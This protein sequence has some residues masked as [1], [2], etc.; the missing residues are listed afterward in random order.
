MP[1]F[2]A[3]LSFSVPHVWGLHVA[4]D[5]VLT[6]CLEHLASWPAHVGAE[7]LKTESSK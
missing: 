2:A 7:S 1:L 4:E 3:L 5:R 6:L